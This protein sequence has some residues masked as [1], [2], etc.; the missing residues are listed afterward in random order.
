MFLK[1]LFSYSVSCKKPCNLGKYQNM[2]SLRD[3]FRA[4][5]YLRGSKAR[6]WGI[7]PLPPFQ[8]SNPLKN[9]NLPI[10]AKAKRNNRFVSGAPGDEKILH[11][12]G[13]KNTFLREKMMFEAE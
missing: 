6:Q 11:P 12:G 9:S 2:E 7:I 1:V 10:S 4:S 8:T 13:R 5:Q 3:H